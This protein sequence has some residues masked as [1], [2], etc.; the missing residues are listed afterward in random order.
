MSIRKVAD[1]AAKEIL[2]SLGASTDKT[3][4][5]SHI[6]EKALL[7]VMRDTHVEYANVVN[8]CCSADQDLAHK[9]SDEL[10]QKEKALIANL[11][12]LR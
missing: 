3:D 2:A 11:S 4:D 5:V 1:D 7:A 10:R 6:V 12:S 8:V 9:I